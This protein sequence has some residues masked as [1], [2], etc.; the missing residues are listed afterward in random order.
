MLERMLRLTPGRAARIV[1][2]FSSSLAIGIPGDLRAQSTSPAS[3]A[4]S[5]TQAAQVS[6]AQPSPLVN[7]ALSV[8]ER[9]RL[10]TQ[11]QRA[12]ERLK[13]LS[14]EADALA[15]QQ[16]TVLGELQRLELVRERHAA[17]E[18]A[19]QAAGSLARAAVTDTLRRIGALEAKV[20][21]RAPAVRARVARLYKLGQLDA[22]RYWVRVDGLVQTARAWRLLATVATRDR[23]VLAAAARDRTQLDR[24]RVEQQRRAAEAEQLA[25]TAQH[26][27]AGAVRAMAAR[28]ALVV[29]LDS[30]RD[31]AARL[32]GEL[33]QAEDHL[34]ALI[35][36]APGAA[37]KPGADNPAALLPLAPFKGDLDWPVAGAIV[38][39]FG[40]E[41]QSRFGTVLP[42]NGLEIAAAESTPVQ[43]LHEGRVVFADA[44][45]GLGRLVIVDHASNAFSLYGHLG[46]I[47]V[48]RGDSVVRGSRIG[49]VGQTPAGTQALYFELRID[50]QPVDPLEWM[51]PPVDRRSRP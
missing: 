45:A 51:K 27:R 47:A 42:R 11:A 49:S 32:M 3:P 43:A 8:R 38:T 13:V 14:R 50:G 41:R 36:A 2:T 5:R 15:A 21:A 17:E 33:Q 40:R 31:L 18:Q 6:S 46:E 25:R 7:L 24:L 16:R 26:A 44:F 22:A 1:V 10:E 39:R 23:E 34:K 28:Q 19:A 29:R 37:Q 48:H 12:R 4:P 20:A 35:A 9:V 30:E